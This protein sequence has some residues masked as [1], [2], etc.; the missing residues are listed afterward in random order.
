M[1]FSAWG[2]TT[3]RRLVKI[4]SWLLA[5]RSG[6]RNRETWIRPDRTDHGCC[7]YFSSG[8][9]AAALR[10]LTAPDTPVT[11][12]WALTQPDA[13]NPSWIF[14]SLLNGSAAG[15]LICHERTDKVVCCSS[16]TLQLGAVKSPKVNQWMAPLIIH[17][18]AYHCLNG[19]KGYLENLTCAGLKTAVTYNFVS[20]LHAYYRPARLL[21]RA[22]ERCKS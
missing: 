4:L 11:F 16:I 10:R 21:E 15:Q 6:S 14:A 2:L 7:F 18:A 9:A 17:R 1:R 8:D 19:I 12:L 13:T 20:Y 22:A 3:G 5:M